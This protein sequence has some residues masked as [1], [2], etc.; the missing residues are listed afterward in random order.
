MDAKRS[1]TTDNKEDTSHA[2][3]RTTDTIKMRNKN[4]EEGNDRK[5][6]A[7]TT[8]TKIIKNERQNYEER[9]EG[10][11]QIFTRATRIIKTM[12]K[13]EKRVKRA[14]QEKG[15]LKE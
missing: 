3:T 10:K 8:T 2:I 15:G 7:F 12:Y 9:N 1:K 6:H 13:I 5:T 14:I 11:N 4:R